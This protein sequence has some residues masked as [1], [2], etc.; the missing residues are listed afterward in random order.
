MNYVRNVKAIQILLLLIG[1]LSVSCLCLLLRLLDERHTRR[2]EV[3]SRMRLLRIANR[4]VTTAFDERFPY[5]FRTPELVA[6]M[7]TLSSD[8]LA[9]VYV[10]SEDEFQSIVSDLGESVEILREEQGDSLLIAMAFSKSFCIT[11]GGVA[12]TIDV[13]GKT[14]WVGVDTTGIGSKLTFL[15]EREGYALLIDENSTRFHVQVQELREAR[16]HILGFLARQRV[17]HHRQEDLVILGK[18]ANECER[19]DDLL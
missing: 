14:Q 4:G 8:S 17:Q 1:A 11:V 5:R 3:E 19:S 18:S 2:Q 10:S 12:T 15:A 13:G 9:L 16:K 7:N 6:A